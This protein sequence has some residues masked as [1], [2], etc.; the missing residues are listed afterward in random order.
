ME[1]V[2]TV[3]IKD[4][5]DTERGTLENSLQEITLDSN[6]ENCHNNTKKTNTYIREFSIHVPQRFLSKP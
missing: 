6:R 2:N 4:M 5:V 3:Y 1:T